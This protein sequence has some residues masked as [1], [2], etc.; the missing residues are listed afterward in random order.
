LRCADYVILSDADI[1]FLTCPT[2][3]AKGSE[4]RGK[5]VD[6]PNPPEAIWRSLAQSAG[7]TNPKV[8][9]IE[10]SP[11]SLTFATNFNGGLYVIPQ[12]QAE[13]L[14]HLWPKWASFCLNQPEILGRY[15]HHSD[16]IGFGFAAQ[17]IE[18]SIRYLNIQD[19]FPIHLKSFLQSVEARP[20]R[21]I[22]YHS[23][24]DEDGLLK[25]PGIDWIDEQIATLNQN[26][27]DFR[28][29]VFVHDT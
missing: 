26:L 19:N 17:E 15:I 29:Q 18:A 13:R 7:F 6:L 8:Q 28:S 21:A 16:Q 11:G 23:E 10:L 27:S 25:L 24:F 14:R 20:L 1:V 3:H 2:A 5:L 12:W 22:H 9:E 4:I